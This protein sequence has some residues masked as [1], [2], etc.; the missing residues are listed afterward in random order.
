MKKLSSITIG[1]FLF[2]AIACKK[3]STPGS[4]PVPPPPIDTSTSAI[5]YT[6][7]FENGPYGTATGTAKIVESNGKYSLRLE[8]FR[9]SSGPDLKVYISKE[10]QPLNFIRLGNLQAL[11][12]DQAYSIPGNPDFMEYRYALIHC[13]RFNHLFGSALLMEK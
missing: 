13:E 9:V 4:T 10:K 8:G 12:G 5:K 7:M 11:S 1:V 3:E 6:G 2:I